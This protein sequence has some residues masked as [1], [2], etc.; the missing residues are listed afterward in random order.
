MRGAMRSP[1]RD[2]TRVPSY[3]ACH[4]AMLISAIQQCH[5]HPLTHC[6]MIAPITYNAAHSM[7]FST[8][9]NTEGKYGQAGGGT[10]CLDAA[11]LGRR[12]RGAAGDPALS[13]LQPATAS[14]GADVSAMWLRR[15]SGVAGDEWTGHDLQLR[16]GIRL[17]DQTAAAGPTFQRRGN[18]VGRGPGDPD[19]LPPPGNAGGCGPRGGPCRSGLRGDGKRP[20]GPRVAGRRRVPPAFPGPH[21]AR[22]KEHT[23]TPQHPPTS[24]YR[25]TEG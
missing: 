2:D 23:M 11:L 7:T 9:S 19:V 21:N 14:T 16:R 22:R 25:T 24:L 8:L 4:K 3:T 17:P 15:P 20:K 13:R 18:H 12:Q 5:V 10:R 1:P 6:V